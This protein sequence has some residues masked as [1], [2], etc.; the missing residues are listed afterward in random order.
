[1]AVLDTDGTLLIDLDAILACQA[2]HFC[3]LS[4]APTLL[5]HDN[6][7]WCAPVIMEPLWQRMLQSLW[8]VW[9][10]APLTICDLCDSVGVN[11]AP[12]LDRVQYPI[13][14]VMPDSTLALLW[15]ALNTILTRHEI[16]PSVKQGEVVLL[17]KGGSPLDMNNYRGIYMLQTYYKLI[18]TT[19]ARRLTAAMEDLLLYSNATGGS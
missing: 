6:L 15:H 9:L 1:M 14:R 7:P 3:E 16:P 8:L 17:H 19:I 10:Q 5:P 2:N 13:L 18:T 11:T 12:G 4:K